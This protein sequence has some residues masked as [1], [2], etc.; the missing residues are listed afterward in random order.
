MDIEYGED[1]IDGF[2]I[3]SYMPPPGYGSGIRHA[4]GIDTYDMHCLMPLPVCHWIRVH[5]RL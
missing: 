5:A 2:R 4:L 1:G 3:P